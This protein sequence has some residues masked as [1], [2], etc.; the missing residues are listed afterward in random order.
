MTVIYTFMLLQHY[1][2]KHAH[3]YHTGYNSDYRDCGAAQISV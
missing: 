3:L 1:G 2:L